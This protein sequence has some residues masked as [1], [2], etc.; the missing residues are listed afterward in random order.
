MQRCINC[1]NPVPGDVV[2]INDHCPACWEED[3]GLNFDQEAAE[4]LQLLQRL[5]GEVRYFAADLF[6]AINDAKADEASMA[7]LE[8]WIAVCIARGRH[9]WYLDEGE[10]YCRQC[11][12]RQPFQKGRA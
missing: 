1:G 8:P 5:A 6:A 11:G 9:E 7:G 2:M 12:A 10:M 4:G 3:Y